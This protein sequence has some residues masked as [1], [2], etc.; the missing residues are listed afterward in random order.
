MRLC[1]SVCARDCVHSLSLARARSLSRTYTCTCTHTHTHKHICAC[2]YLV[3][4]HTFG[5]TH[6]NLCVCVCVSKK[7]IGIANMPIGL[8]SRKEAFVFAVLHG[9][10]VGAIQA[11][12]R[13][14]FFLRPLSLPF[15]HGCALGPIQDYSPTL[16]LLFSFEAFLSLR[17]RGSLLKKKIQCLYRS[18]G[19]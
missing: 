6:M 3:R 15:L 16:Y 14:F 9:C 8:K 10:A 18:P 12:S 2:M 19:S 13:R 5:C 11:Y 7:K 17:V 4:K 1:V